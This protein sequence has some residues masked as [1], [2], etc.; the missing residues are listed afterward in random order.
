MNQSLVQVKDQ[1]FFGLQLWRQY[2]SDICLFV[3]DFFDE[4]CEFCFIDIHLFSLCWICCKGLA[5]GLEAVK[6]G[7]PRSV[8]WE[9]GLIGVL[10]DE[11]ELLYSALIFLVSAGLVFF[12][13]LDNVA[14]WERKY[15]RGLGLSYLRWKREG[16]WGFSLSLS[17]MY[18]FLCKFDFSIIQNSMI[19][20]DLLIHQSWC[21]IK[22]YLFISLTNLI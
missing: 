22:S 3:S 21:S 19:T 5:D 18:F 17:C 13:E 16:F 10:F 20:I 2:N 14:K 7:K 15:L 8:I 12:S 1:N 11:F 6:I 4:F 9:L